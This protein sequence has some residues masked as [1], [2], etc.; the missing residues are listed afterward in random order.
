MSEKILHRMVRSRAQPEPEV[1]IE[2]GVETGM[3][4]ALERFGFESDIRVLPPE[5]LSRKQLAETA[6]HGV[7]YQLTGAEPGAFACDAALR[8]LFI[9]ARATS[10]MTGRFLSERPTTPL[11]RVLFR[12]WCEACLQQVQFE[13]SEAGGDV[14]RHCVLGQPILNA[15]Q[16]LTELT[17]QKYQCFRVQITFAEGVG[18]GEMLFALPIILPVSA[19]PPQGTT[20]LSGVLP[21]LP[22]TVEAI[23]YDGRMNA[24]ELSSLSVGQVVPLWGASLEQVSLR[25]TGGTEILTARLGQTRGQRAVKVTDES[26][27]DM[28][29]TTIDGP[30]PDIA[31][32]TPSALGERVDLGSQSA[33]VI[34]EARSGR[35]DLV[36]GHGAGHAE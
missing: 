15:R 26:A 3:L 2:T 19:D 30:S 10:A 28:E 7:A 36:G 25:T 11:D 35:D 18:A 20:T 27:T 12:Q 29:E 24:G 5:E 1:P 21:R 6:P 34:A 23:L 13:M 8:D 17:A 22:I 32:S 14:W 31:Q 4:R 33:Q 16:Y 9:E